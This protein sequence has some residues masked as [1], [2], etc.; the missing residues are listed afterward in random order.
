MNRLPKGNC[1]YCD[2]ERGEPSVWGMSPA[3]WEEMRKRHESG[4]QSVD[5]IPLNHDLRLSM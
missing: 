1:P 5:T 2:A 4:H 3:G